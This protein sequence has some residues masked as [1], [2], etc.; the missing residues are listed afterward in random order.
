MKIPSLKKC[1]RKKF[2]IYRKRISKNRK[3]M[4]IYKNKLMIIKKKFNNYKNYWIAKEKNKE[5][6][7]KYIVI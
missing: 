2:R 7:I 3:K 1:R 5:V 4:M 6:I